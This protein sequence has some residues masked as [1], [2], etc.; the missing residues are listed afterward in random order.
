[1]SHSSKDTKLIRLIELAFANR[2]IEPY[3]AKLRMEGKNP[4]E[5]IVEAIGKSIGLFALIT[6]TVVEDP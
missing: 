2:E 1:M 3:F 4:V 5:K 6:P